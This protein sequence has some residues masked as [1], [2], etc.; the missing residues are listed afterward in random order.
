MN[1]F[2]LKDGMQVGAAG[3]A[4]QIEG[5]EPDHSWLD[6]SRKGHIADGS[7]PARANDHYNRWREDAALMRD[8]NIQ[9]Y[10]LGVEWARI[11]PQEGV[12][13]EDAIAHYVS[14]I[15]LLK[16]YGIE[17]LVTL[18]HFTNPMWFE[19]KGA[20]EKKENIAFFIRFAE[21]IVSAFGPLV[22]E[23]ITVNEPNVYAVNGYF[24]GIWPPGGKSML[25]TVR[26]MSVLAAAHIEAYK[27]IHNLR[28]QLGFDDTKVSFAN[29]V[30]VFAPEDPNNA[31]H[32]FFAKLN[33]RFFQGALSKAMYT[34]VF[35]FPVSN[36]RHAKR[37]RYCDFI[38]LN[39]YTRS[40][41]SGLRDGVREGAPV[42][43]LG[44]EIYPQ[45]IV[46]CAEKLYRISPLP[47]YITENGTCDNNDDFRSLY[48]YE[49]LKALCESELP[50]SRY[51]HWCFCDNF[52]WAEG[53]S[54][55]FGIVHVDYETQRREI[56][57]SGL[58]LR[59]L[60]IAHGVDEKIF[61]EYIKTE[62]YR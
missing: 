31:S 16:S 7:S 61:D 15:E 14:E 41:V 11:E 40:T 2:S 45:G 20:F 36:V 1:V 37:G 28:K 5:G 4:T 33:E 30:R 56:K 19:K 9:I 48:I 39:Y 17:A 62:Q 25:K 8:L 23:Y 54:A 12:F 34:G 47:V 26:V 18:H 13:D 35:P 49:H 3:A 57:K 53:E 59:D 29:H 21:K 58:F 24:F 22:R 27:V 32:R 38:A 10:R 44:W 50:V 46:E 43:D 60:I 42:N 6:W 51:Y 55:R 52:E